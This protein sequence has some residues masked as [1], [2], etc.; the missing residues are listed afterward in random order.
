M[1]KLTD[2]ENA[3][4]SSWGNR[5]NILENPNVI[6]I[7]AGTNTFEYP[8][9]KTDTGTAAMVTITVP[10]N[11]FCGRITLIPGGA[12]TWTAAGNIGVLGT[13]VAS[14]ALD[15]VYLPVA[16]KWYPTYV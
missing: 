16:A 2:L 8:I 1:S 4:K 12:F 15:F 10:Y 14:R 6:T 13:A 11:G 7:A 3:M 9:S 5:D